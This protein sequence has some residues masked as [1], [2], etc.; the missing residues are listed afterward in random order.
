MTVLRLVAVLAG[1]LMLG[2]LLVPRF[3]RF[4]VGL[5]R[6][7]ITLVVSI[8]ICFSIALLVKSIG[9]SV[10]LGAFLA[11]SLI[12]ESGEEK[13]VERLV[14]PVRDMF[15]AVFFVSVGMMIDPAVIGTHWPTIVGFTLIVV[16]GKIGAV[17]LAAFL[18]GAGVRTAVQ[19]GMTMAQIGEFAFI[20]AAAGLAAGVT[21]P[22]H[23]PIVVAVSALTTLTTPWLIRFAGPAAEW[24]DRHLPRPLQTFAVLYGTWMEGLR[25]GAD[26]S[27]NKLR[28]RRAFRALALD[29]CVVAAL[30]IGVSI[31]TPAL[32]ASLARRTGLLPFHAQGVVVGGAMLLSVPFLVGIFRTGRALGY[33]LSFRSFPEPEPKKLDLAAAPRRVM[34]VAIQLTTVLVVGAP[35]VAVT[36]PF[37]PPFAGVA[38]LLV[39]VTVLGIFVWRGAAD[40][41]G[42]VRAAAE[43]IVSAIGTQPRGSAPQEAERTLHRA[44]H[45]LPGLGE[46]VPVRIEVGSPFAGRQLSDTD[47]RGRTGATVIAISR[48][49][50]MV[51]VPDGHQDLRA[52][53]V[54]ALAGPRSAIEAARQLLAHGE[55]FASRAVETPLEPGA[56]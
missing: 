27:A 36:Q 42:H 11:G 13:R 49:E 53:D 50:E 6:S 3:M 21:P 12:A 14:E 43:A 26:T 48:G 34:I 54:L 22:S 9:Y 19:T 17:S 24:L 38:V 56:L 5:Q 52:G 2:T 4:V 40:L 8:G 44:Y 46:P 31:A 55:E 10:A 23:Y 20:I 29:A 18:T 35:L 45:L 37:L 47:L 32:A 51:L 15:A 28:L 41:Q 33:T 30:G 7:E 1:F 39:G 16:L 25:T